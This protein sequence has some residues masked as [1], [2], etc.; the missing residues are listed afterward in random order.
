MEVSVGVGL[1][2]EFAGRDIRRVDYIL[3]GVLLE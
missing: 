1:M 2:V 3:V